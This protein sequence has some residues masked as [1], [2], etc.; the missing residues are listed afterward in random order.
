MWL[1]GWDKE[2]EG[3]GGADGGERTTQGMGV[4]KWEKVG[5]KAKVE[6]NER[7]RMEER[8]KE[9]GWGWES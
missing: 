4:G 8:G 5:E 3:D 2:A 6:R 7:E 9:R 1:S